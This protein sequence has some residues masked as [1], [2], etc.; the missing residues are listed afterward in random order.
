MDPFDIVSSITV[1]LK[2]N[3]QMVKAYGICSMARH[4][5]DM[6]P[7][8]QEDKL[9][10]AV[11]SFPGQPQRNYNPY[12][13]VY[14]PG[15]RDHPNLNYENQQVNQPNFQQYRQPYLLRQQHDQT[16]SSVTH[17][18]DIVKSLATNT[19]QFQQ[20]TRA[21]TKSLENQLGQMTTTI[22][23]LEAQCLGKLPSQTMVNPRENISAILLRSGKEVEIPRAIPI[24][25][26][27]EKDKDVLEEKNALVRYRKDERDHELYDTF[28]RCKINVPLID[29]I[30]QISRYAKFL[31]HLCKSKGKQKLKG[32]EKINVKD[33]VSTIIQR[34]LPAKCTDPSMF[35]IPCTIGDTNFEKAMIES[36]AS[37]NIMPYSIYASLKLGPLNETS[38]VIQLAN[39]SNVY[40]KGLV[41]DILVKVNDLIF[42]TDFY[43]LDMEKKILEPNENNAVKVSI[44]K[45]IEEVDQ[46]LPQILL[47]RK[48]LQ[49]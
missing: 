32:Y 19:L 16:L 4:P 8:L 12:S 34:K 48:L 6:C 1:L 29:S 46:E 18:E 26:E 39:E 15:W 7:T 11:G 17:L 10:N 35:T 22:N 27:Q 5:T 24:S 28:G 2:G 25:L 38:V 40:P 13:N 37:I 47:Y 21:S 31:K 14:N 42:P 36:G 44:D 41:E 33:N 43:V 9:V 23:M 3:M 49:H 20:E 45:H 30:K